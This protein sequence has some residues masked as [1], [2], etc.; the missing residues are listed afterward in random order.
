MSV[1]AEGAPSVAA[2]PPI[3][4]RRP[5]Q[6]A[7]NRN[8]IRACPICQDDFL[9]GEALAQ[10][11]CG[12]RFHRVCIDGWIAT[13]E[14]D[15]EI[16]IV[17]N[18]VLQPPSCPLCRVVINDPPI[19]VVAGRQDLQGVV[20]GSLVV[21][22][23][24]PDSAQALNTP[25]SMQSSFQSVLTTR[26]ELAGSPLLPWWPAGEHCFHLSTSLTDGRLSIIIDPGAWTNLLGEVLAR[27]LVKRALQFGY[28]PTQ[29][30]LPKPLRIQGVGNG[31]QEC[32]H[33]LRVPIAVPDGQG[34]AFIH[35]LE[36]PVVGGT[37]KDLPGLLGLKTIETL[38][39]TLDTGKRRLLL[40]GLEGQ[41]DSPGTT[42]I[43]LEKAPSGHLVM[44]VDSYELVHP[45]RGGLADSSLTLHSHLPAP[46]RGLE[47]SRSATHLQGERGWTS[48]SRARLD[49]PPQSARQ[50]ASSSVDGLREL[51]SVN[52][53]AAD[54]AA[55]IHFNE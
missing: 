12:H 26:S 49:T 1:D 42:E 19:E 43:P 23:H 24:E 48:Q 40:P 7:I 34:R 2:S 10:L 16:A 46:E 36:A 31:H 53:A 41:V 6:Q 22:I 11:H 29:H 54:A 3:T 25:T 27:L 51:A 32:T 28:K 39:G 33:A 20:E 13:M 8:P 38:R 47:R 14:Q 50:D 9:I 44:V 37:G 55:D 21:P 35:T 5:Q 52:L 17:H 30:P 4:P 18:G 45:P 15:V